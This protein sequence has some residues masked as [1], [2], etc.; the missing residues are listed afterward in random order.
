M[1]RFFR[2]DLEGGGARDWKKPPLSDHLVEI[3]RVIER[4]GTET[5][6]SHLD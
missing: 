4:V 1:G 3:P 5:F 6:L 2:M